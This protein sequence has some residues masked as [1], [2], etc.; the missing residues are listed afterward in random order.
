MINRWL[1]NNNRILADSN[2][3]LIKDV[4][5]TPSLITT[6][7]WYD[8]SDLNTITEDS[9]KVSQWDDKSGSGYHLEQLTASNQPSIGTG[10]ISGL[11]AIEFQDRLLGSPYAQYLNVNTNLPQFDYVAVVFNRT[12]GQVFSQ[13]VGSQTLG[14]GNNYTVQYRGDFA[15]DRWQNSSFTNGNPVSLNGALALFDPPA[16]LVVRDNLALTDFDLQVGADRGLSNRSWDG[17]MGEIIC[18]SGTL[19]MELRQ[20]IEGYLAW[21]WGLVSSLPSDHPYKNS[22]PTV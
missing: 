8:A 1:S 20:K 9:G 17:F 14:G 21:K 3:A 15:P 10:T 2:R 13:A 11:N 16:C 5:W 22:R 19:T 4:E 18:G 6:L 12:F 7:A